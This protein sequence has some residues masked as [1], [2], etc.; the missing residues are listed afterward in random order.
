[1]IGFLLFLI[2]FILLCVTMGPA[3]FM[4]GIGLMFFI[5][6]YAVVS[7]I[8]SAVETSKEQICPYCRAQIPKEA[9]VCKYCTRDISP[10]KS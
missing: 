8:F 1:M 9:T 2:I 4:I 6:V 10:N 3:G 7:L 5:G